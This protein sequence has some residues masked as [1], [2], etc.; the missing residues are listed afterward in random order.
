MF[1]RAETGVPKADDPSK[2]DVKADFIKSIQAKIP[3]LSAF[4]LL[5]D[6]YVTML[7]TFIRSDSI[8]EY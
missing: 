5:Q 7:E 4:G 1:A 2:I 8:D 3:L 6:E